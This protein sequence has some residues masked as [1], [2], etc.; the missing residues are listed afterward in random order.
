MHRLQNLLHVESA[1]IGFASCRIFRMS[2]APE[3]EQRSGK[4]PVLFCYLRSGD[5]HPLHLLSFA[6]GSNKKMRDVLKFSAILPPQT[7]AFLISRS[8]RTLALV[9]PELAQIQ[10]DLHDSLRISNR[11]TKLLETSL[12]HRKQRTDHIPNRD[13][14]AF[15]QD[16]QNPKADEN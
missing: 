4:V 9:V 3:C 2:I 12:T 15:F 1:P 5:F 11:D 14:N 10:K 6:R 7:A 8:N 13:K 16:P